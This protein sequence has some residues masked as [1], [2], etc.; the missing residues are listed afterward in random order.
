[1][2]PPNRRPVSRR[3]FLAT[4]L[5]TLA[6]VPLSLLA[7]ISIPASRTAGADPSTGEDTTM[8][9]TA[10]PAAPLPVEGVLPSL[11]GA[12]AWL[13]SPPLTPDG[14]RGKVVLAELLTYTCINW[15]R[16]MPYVRAWSE[17]YRDHGLAVLGVHTPELEFEQDIENVRRAI[18]DLRV[19]FPVA[20]DSEYGVWRAFKNNYWPALYFVDGAARIRHHRFGEGEYD[21]SEMVL[22]QLL[23]EAG[24]DGFERGLVSVA[25]Q[26]V[27]AAPDW[28]N[29]KSPEN[30]LGYRRTERFASPG[31]LRPDSRNAYTASTQLRLNQWALAG[32]WTVGMQAAALH[33]PGGSTANRFHGRD[34]HLVMGPA[35]RGAPVR[36][37]VTLGGQAPGEA[38]GVDTDE[39]GL[40]TVTE[41]RMYQLI[42]QP[43]PLS[44]A[45]AR[46]SFSTRVRRRSRS[47]SA[48]RRPE[49]G[50]GT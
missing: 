35:T 44:T 13:N 11:T 41:Q 8:Q 27:E 30:Y 43:A 10:H 1:M 7:C 5:T 2:S 29:L 25:G 22:Q 12:T 23:A 18:A 17:K 14:L 39:Q 33:K 36:F 9:Q 16:T 32:E 48:D 38:H 37:R 15:L 49:P 4:S 31:G 40:G 24:Q 6:A 20:V 50:P 34:L 21:R 19:E 45:Y 3:G 46:S 42:R 47:R 28:G 26:G